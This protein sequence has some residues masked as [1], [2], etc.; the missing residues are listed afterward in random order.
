MKKIELYPGIHS[1]ILGFGCAPIKGAV[2]G[3]DAQKAID[4]ALELGINHFDLARSYGYGEAEKF[5]GNLLKGKRDKVVIASKFGIRSTQVAKILKPVKPLIRY[6]RKSSAPGKNEKNTQ[7]IPN[8][9]ANLLSNRVV[10]TK[11]EMKK[12]LEDSLSA[13]KTDYLDYFFIHEPNGSL[14]NIEELREMA[15]ILKQEGKIRAWGLASMAYMLPQ[16]HSYLDY[17]DILQFNNARGDRKYSTILERRKNECN[18]IFSP[19]KGITSNL[20]PEEKFQ[21]LKEQYTKSIFLTSMFN[22]KHII[23]NSSHFLN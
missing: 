16:H 19:L 4:C 9:I 11:K 12:S 8:G 22:E 10:L 21:E 2:S 18:I 23:Q 3:K 17:F 20:S 7:N 6:F 15:E 5:V 14:T 13:L 1:S